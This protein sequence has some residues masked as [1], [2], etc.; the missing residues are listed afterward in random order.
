MYIRTKRLIIKAFNVNYSIPKGY[1]TRSSD[2]YKEYKQKKEIINKAIKMIVE[3]QLSIKYGYKDG[4]TYFEFR[5]IAETKGIKHKRQYS[6]HGYY[7][8][9]K[10][11]KFNG[12]WIGFPN[13]INKGIFIVNKDRVQAPGIFDMYYTHD[14]ESLHHACI[15]FLKSN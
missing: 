1:G 11:K 7:G 3:N 8:N 10:N 14:A 2:Y 9:G 13:E 5:D 15:D 12:E 4:V 6:F